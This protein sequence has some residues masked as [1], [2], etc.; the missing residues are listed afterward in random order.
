VT[1]PAHRLELSESQRLL[2][3]AREVIPGASQT[4]SKGP[5]QFVE[6]AAPAFCERADGARIWDVDGNEYLDYTIALGPMIL[7]YCHPEVDE[8]VREQLALGTTF[9]LPHRIEVELAEEICRLVP[10]A[11]MVRYGKSG[12]DAVA[13][14]VRIAR[15]ATGRESVLFCG[16]HGW[17]DW[18]IGA[19]TRSKGVPE[20]VR[21]LTASF[22]YG[23]LDALE[24]LL[25]ERNPAAVVLEPVGIVEPPANYLRGLVTLAHEHGALVVFDEIIT[26]FRLRLGG[27]QEY[28][29]VQ[30]DLAA[31]GKAVANGMPLSVVAGRRDLMKEF[32]EIFFS[33]THGGEALS[34][35]AALAT[36]RVL[37]RD[38]VIPSLWRR[39]ESLVSGLRSL[40]ERHGLDGRVVCLGYAPR[41]AVLFRDA[42]G[43]DSL[44]LK[45]LFQQECIKRGVLFT[46]SQFISA[47]HTDDDVTRTLDVYDEALGELADAVAHG[48]AAARLE[49]RPVQPVFRQP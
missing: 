10:C 26:G 44:E 16:Y 38:D 21:A 27:A 9:T 43:R 4:F 36:L 6:G 2:E 30:P 20:A 39:G 14:A 8:A 35:A 45:S 19:T 32:E 17:H 47:A 25:L 34:L 13:A 41:T 28:F 31:F 22:P 48:D 18:H 46:G 49:G 23:D 42:D 15:A 29:G 7:G 5:T 12:S 11:E 33:I 1:I 37:E 24:A 40:V 3:R